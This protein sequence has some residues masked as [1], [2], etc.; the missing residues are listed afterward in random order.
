MPERPRTFLWTALVVLLLLGGSAAVLPW[1]LEAVSSWGGF[2]DALERLTRFVGAFLS[3]DLSGEMLQRCAWLAVETV[4]VAGLGTGLGLLIAYPI[5]LGASRCVVLGDEPVRGINGRLQRLG[6]ELCRLTLDAMRGVPDFLWAIVLATITGVNAGT[7]V[8]AIAV[9]V[10]GI[11]GK[12]LSEQW[13]NIDP[14]RYQALRSTGAGRLRVFLYGVQPLAAR[15]MQSFVLMRFECAVRNASVIGVVG[16][17]GLGAALWDEFTDLEYSRVATVLL[18]LLVVTTLTD[19]LANLL[20]HQLRVDPNH[21]RAN[22]GHDRA[23]AGR[24]RRGVA[25]VIAL[26]V[27]GAIAVLWRPLGL[28]CEELQRVEWGYISKYIG[29]LTVPDL[30]GERLLSAARHSLIPLGL[31][32]L[33]TALAAM[34][35]AALAFPGSVAFQIEA[36]RFTGERVAGVR[37]VLRWALLVT[38]RLLALVMRGIPEVAWVLLLMVFFKQGITPCVFAVALHSAGVLLRVFTETLD[39]VPYRRLEQVHGACRGHLFLYGALPRALSDW[40]TY[41]FFQFEVNVRIGIALGI[42]GAGGLGD[43]FQSNLSWRVFDGASTYLW[44]MVL[45]TVA[46]DRTSRL[47]QIRRL[48]C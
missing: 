16:G 15:A 23:T 26:L 1:N 27:A 17:G 13:D 29:R 45:L 21:P 6:L 38:T 44:A 11:Y 20:R 10:G 47:L 28:V 2:Q 3:P 19:L 7:G 14:Q 25:I 34:V 5:A 41:A 39:N 22:R 33:A 24:R 37:R 31:G 32:L 12:V 48:K 4:A 35:A 8:L 40:R 42:V 46:I 18:S 9:S 43:R 30:S 36:S